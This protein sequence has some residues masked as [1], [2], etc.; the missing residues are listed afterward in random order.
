MKILLI[1]GTGSISTNISRK[2]IKDG[3]DLYLLNRGYSKNILGEKGVT[4]ITCDI[5][6]EK[7]VSE[8]IS[9]L[10]F[11]VIAD[12]TA[13]KK[14]DIERDYRLFKGKTD[15]YIF[16]SSATVYQK[17]MPGYVVTEGTSLGN[18]IYLQP[19]C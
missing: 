12:F 16:I 7:K 1:G 10:H 19:L 3:Q 4:Y 2:L 9:D 18:Q 17:L 5:N 11:D 13:F 6:D 15:Q 14:E 8:W